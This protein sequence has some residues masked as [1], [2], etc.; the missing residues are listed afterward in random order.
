MRPAFLLAAA[1][2]ALALS[3]CSPSTKDHTARAAD[4][5]GAAASSATRDAGAA[6]RNAADGTATE[7]RMARRKTDA[8]ADAAAKTN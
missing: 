5:A 8:A 4:Q 3:A 7:L 2:A 6:A 1:A